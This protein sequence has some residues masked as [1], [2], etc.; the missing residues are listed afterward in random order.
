MKYINIFIF[1]NML[2]LYSSC[3]LQYLFYIPPQDININMQTLDESL[4]YIRSYEYRVHVGGTFTPE[5][6]YSNGYG[7]CDDLSMLLLYFLTKDLDIEAY[8]ILG[9]YNNSM[10]HAW[11]EVGNGDWYDATYGGK[12]ESRS[13]FIPEYRYTYED[14]MRNILIYGGFIDNDKYI[15]RGLN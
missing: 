3:L 6:T 4:D 15:Y 13:L 11:V 7:D 2:Y 1:I 9:K 5:E 8:I 10:N 12:I 14:A